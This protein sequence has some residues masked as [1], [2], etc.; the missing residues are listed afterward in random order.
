MIKEFTLK[1][2]QQHIASETKIRIEWSC[3]EYLDKAEDLENREWY[4]RLAKDHL[5][6]SVLIRM[7]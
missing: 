7:Q 3:L 2:I 5:V 4:T 1:G 6:I